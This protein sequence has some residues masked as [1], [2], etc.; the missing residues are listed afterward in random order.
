MNIDW[1]D[2]KRYGPPDEEGN[3]LCAFSDGDIQTIT[4]NGPDDKFWDKDNK[5]QMTHWAVITPEMHPD[6]DPSPETQEEV[7][8]IGGWG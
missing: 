1:V 3:Y 6:Y 7:T 8:R 5:F 2:L 4:Y